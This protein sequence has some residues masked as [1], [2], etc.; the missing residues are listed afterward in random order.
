MRLK[1]LDWLLIETHWGIKC[2]SQ[3]ENGV[4][5]IGL[6]DLDGGNVIRAGNKELVRLIGDYELVGVTASDLDHNS[7]AV[8]IGAAT[9]VLV[10]EY[11]ALSHNNPNPFNP[12]TQI[13]FS[14]P[15]NADVELTVF[16]IL[17]RRVKTLAS[18]QYESGTA[19]YIG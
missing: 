6:V 12:V 4:L 9:A 18:S 13:F 2:S 16:N 15:V 3:V 17:G 7:I 14:L 19:G 11:F 5:K 10:P 8:R 1:A